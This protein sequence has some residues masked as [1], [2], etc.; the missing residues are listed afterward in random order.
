MY[1]FGKV[2]YYQ[3]YHLVGGNQYVPHTFYFFSTQSKLRSAT[4]IEDFLEFLVALVFHFLSWDFVL[5][6]SY[7][8]RGKE[9]GRMGGRGSGKGKW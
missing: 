2:T 7:M 5:T 8:E 1:K 3:G 9:G 6:K 4:I